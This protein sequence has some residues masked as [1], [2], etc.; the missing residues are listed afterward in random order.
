MQDGASGRSKLSHGWFLLKKC[1]L[2]LERSAELE[3]ETASAGL[4]VLC[5]H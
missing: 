3:I 4:L 5:Q 2:M 1:L